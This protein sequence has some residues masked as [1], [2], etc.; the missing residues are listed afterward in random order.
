[1]S[2]ADKRNKY[3]E[4]QPKILP[5]KTLIVSESENQNNSTTAVMREYIRQ[6]TAE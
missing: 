2:I 4:F 1:M 5:P 6:A 3:D